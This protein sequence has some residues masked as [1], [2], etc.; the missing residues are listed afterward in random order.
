M[1]ITEIRPNL[2]IWSILLSS[3]KFVQAYEL[4]IDTYNMPNMAPISQIIKIEIFEGYIRMVRIFFV[5]IQH[6]PDFYGIFKAFYR[7]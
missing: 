1:N 4:E 3:W 2:L 7:D 5:K 6:F